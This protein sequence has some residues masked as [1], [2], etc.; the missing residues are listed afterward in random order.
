MTH[1]YAVME[2]SS[3]T[4]REIR[5]ALIKAK[6]GHAIDQTNDGEVLDMHGIALQ[7][8]KK[9]R[10]ALLWDSTGWRC[11][12]GHLNSPFTHRCHEC[13]ARRESS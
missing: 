11:A 10:L 1:T 5:N 2:V 13:G 8:A 12:A 7:D 4:Y 3:E 6:Y 9:G